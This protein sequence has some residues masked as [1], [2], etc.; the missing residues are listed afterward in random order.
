MTDATH[1]EPPGSVEPFLIADKFVNLIVG[2]VGSTKTTAAIMKIAYEA[3][4]IAPCRDGIRRSRCAVIRNT[5]QMLN[6][7]TIPDFLKWFPEGVAGSFLRTEKKFILRY[8]D[9][10]CEVLFRG[11]DDGN[12]VRRLL[13]LQLSFGVMDEFREINPDVFNALTGRLGRY[14]DK[15]MN[16]VGCCDDDGNQVHKVWGATNPPD[17]D[18]F[19]GE[20]ITDPPQNAVVI[21]QPSGV[22]PEADWIHLLPTDYYT[23]LCEGK[24]EDWINVYV[25][26]KLGRSLSGQPV[27]SSFHYDTHVAKE[28]LK[29][30]PVL[31]TLWIGLDNGLSP[32][33]VLGQVD[34]SGRILVYDSI[35]AEGK[36]ALRFCREVLKPLLTSKYPG[37]KIQMIADPACAIRAQ[38]D[39]KSI[40]DI[41]RAEGMSIVTAKTNLLPPRL[42]SVEKYL[43][44]TV[45]GKPS[46]LLC[47]EGCKPLISGMRG[48]YRYKANTKGEVAD[49]PEKSHP[50]SD[51]CFAAGTL[52]ATPDGPRAI[53]TLRVG[54]RVCTLDGVDVVTAT[55]DHVAEVI[56]LEMSNGVTITCTPD[57][58]F[59]AGGVGTFVEA[60]ELTPDSDLVELIPTE[61]PARVIRSSYAGKERVYNLTTGRTH[62]YYAEGFL[63]HNCDGLQYLCLHADGGAVY[64]A[65]LHR[66]SARPIKKAAYVYS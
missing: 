18:S 7:T 22:S 29:P 25:H 64:G 27:W 60:Q 17:E 28:M 42:A 35:Y 9:V 13:S 57:H 1:Y 34:P 55:G 65:T 56:T 26:G 31:G 33:A 14:P 8:D 48:K 40:V 66:S 24:S 3:A 63:V 46:L 58:P 41:Y 11:L 61:T 47:P 50:Y 6:D 23:N 2:P 12:D 21:R 38:T 43:T 45:D 39:E 20:Y 5:V 15:S 4:R 51:L 16:G 52:V 53:E 10:E 36:G 37:Y 44:R 30:S 32:A 54:D 49:K 59:A 19:W 62:L